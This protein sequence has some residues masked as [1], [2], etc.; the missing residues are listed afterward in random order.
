MP[1]FGAFLT[2]PQM[3]ALVKYLAARK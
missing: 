1:G 2:E 3:S